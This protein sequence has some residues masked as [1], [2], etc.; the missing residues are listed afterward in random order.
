MCEKCDL[1]GTLRAVDEAAM[2]FGTILRGCSHLR[3][4][5]AAP[6]ADGI[7]LAAHLE[8]ICGKL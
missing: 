7:K 1:H 4:I 8:P 5:L 3:A 6:M 2:C